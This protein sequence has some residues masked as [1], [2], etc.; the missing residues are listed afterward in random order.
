[1]P[2]TIHIP[3]RVVRIYLMALVATGALLT[4][5]TVV[6]A[7]STAAPS[8]ALSVFA[9]FVGVIAMDRGWRGLRRGARP[10]TG[11]EEES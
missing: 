10:C 3:A 7:L 4:L 11:Q 5:T 1:M 6:L 2:T 9:A 8:P